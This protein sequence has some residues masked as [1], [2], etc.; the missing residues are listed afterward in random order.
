MKIKE[1]GKTRFRKNETI[2]EIIVN[3]DKQLRIN[4]RIVNPLSLQ[5]E[6]YKNNM[7]R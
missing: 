7:G 1:V 2:R 5:L 3:E 4:K 6:K